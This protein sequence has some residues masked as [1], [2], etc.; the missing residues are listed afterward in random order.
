MQTQGINL[1]M[2]TVIQDWLQ[3]CQLAL[4]SS[5]WFVSPQDCAPKWHPHRL[6]NSPLFWDCI[7][8]GWHKN[9]YRCCSVNT[10]NI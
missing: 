7:I 5:T 9:T 8:W 4:P 6:A 3:R 1:E 10:Q 2:A